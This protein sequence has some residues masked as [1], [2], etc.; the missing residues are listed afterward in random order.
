MIQLPALYRGVHRVSADLADLTGDLQKFLLGRDFPIV[1]D[2]NFGPQTEGVVKDY[3]RSRCIEV[4]GKVGPQTWG[5]LLAEGFRPVSYRPDAGGFEKERSPAWPPAPEGATSPNGLVLFGQE[6]TYTPHPLP[7]MPEYVKADP[8][9]I[10]DNISTAHIPQLIGVEGA[11]SDGSM[12]FNRHLLFQVQDLFDVWEQR[13]DIGLVLSFAGSWVTRFIRGRRD[14]LSNHSFGTAF[15][16]N[17]AWNGFRRQPALVGSRGS[18]RKL[19]LPAYELGFYW[20]GWYNDGMHFEA[21]KALSGDAL[22]A[23]KERALAL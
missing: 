10:Q 8:E 11:R 2:E 16:I 6:F 17:A 20:G 18:V 21:Y 4:D 15:D 12:L 5:K 23:A 22:K 9:W 1:V 7:S 13:G 14:R 3:Q 19:V